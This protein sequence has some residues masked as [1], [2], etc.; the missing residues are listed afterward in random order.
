[1]KI[2]KDIISGDQL[3]SDEFEKTEVDDVIYEV[4]SKT[5]QKK[6]FGEAHIGIPSEENPSE[7]EKSEENNDPPVNVDAL[8]DSARLVPTSFDKRSYTIYIK[9]YMKKILE[10]LRETNPDRTANFKEGANTFVKKILDSWD[11][12]SYGLFTGRSLNRDGMVVL[13]F[14]KHDGQTTYYY[15]FK[16]GLVEEEV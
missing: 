13:Q 5:V 3:L 1:M 4:K 2:Y 8:I 7:E 12:T 10:K 6:N 15:L 14:Y 11:E 16:D 9:N